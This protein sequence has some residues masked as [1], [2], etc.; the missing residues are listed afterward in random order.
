MKAIIEIASAI[1]A[2]TAAWFW[3]RASQFPPSPEVDWVQKGRPSAEW[4]IS[5]IQ[6]NRRAATCA[7]IAALLQGVSIIAGR[8]SE[9]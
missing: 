3:W 4:T 5:S 9:T 2:F 6:A 1:A 8:F 7:G